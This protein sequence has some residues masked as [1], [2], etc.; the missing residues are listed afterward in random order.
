MMALALTASG[1]PTVSVN[2]PWDGEAFAPGAPIPL[3]AVVA[4]NGETITRVEFLADAGSL[5]DGQANWD[6]EW[7]FPDESHLSVMDGGT[8][9]DYSPPDT[10]PM[11][12]MDGSFVTSNTFVGSFGHF[13]EGGGPVSGAATM[14]FSPGAP[15]TIDVAITGDAP[16]GTRSLT[17]GTKMGGERRYALTWN[18]AAIGTHSVVAKVHYGSGQ[19]VSSEA[20]Q[21]HVSPPLAVA[22]GDPLPVALVGGDY[23]VSL[24]ASGGTPPYQWSLDSGSLPDG[25]NLGTTG[26]ITGSPNA[27]GSS[28]FRVTVADTHGLSA[29]KTYHLLAAS[30]RLRG[31]IGDQLIELDR[32][33]GD[34]TTVAA[35]QP[36]PPTYVLSMAADPLNG[37]LYGVV[38]PD[39]S[40][41]LIRIHPQTGASTIVGFIQTPGNAIQGVEGIAFQPLTGQ[42]YAS[43]R[44]AGGYASPVIISIDPSTAA[45]TVVVTISGTVQND[46]DS[47][48][49]VGS[50]MHALDVDVTSTQKTYL[51][52]INLS[53]GA[54]TLVGWTGFRQLQSLAHDPQRGVFFSSNFNSRE[55]VRIVPATAA[56]TTVGV[57][58]ASGEFGSEALYALAFGL[59]GPIV[60]VIDTSSPL[61][62]GTVGSL[63]QQTL[64]A[65]GGVA[66]CLWSLV[67]GSLPAGLE[68]GA[69][70]VLSGTP[71][72]AV[73]ANFRAR[74]TGVDGGQA[75][76][77]FSLTVTGS[78]T[79]Y[80]QWKA[81]R[82]TTTELEDPGFS[83]DSSDPERDGNPNLLEYALDL[84]P[85]S[86]DAGQGPAAT[87]KD[88]HLE[89]TYRR[90]KQATDMTYEIQASTS[91]KPDS[92]NPVNLTETGREDLGGC[93][94]ITLRDPEP[95]SG[96]PA[97]FVRLKVW[98]P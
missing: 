82:F 69:D 31:A 85:K 11:F 51:Y 43:C 86:P 33:T 5:G 53:T 44:T 14:V 89:F 81:L 40:P 83:G 8:L 50:T 15:D 46:L 20:I 72:S 59:P 63:Y 77:D 67:S 93:W 79:P 73:V 32:D 41:R 47:I 4:A 24:A 18:G 52:T 92:W 66:P 49:F 39:S 22:T 60:P 34:A 55:L 57:T 94:K 78:T 87:V 12:W 25:L 36:A 27:A 71:Q 10:A 65:S 28:T 95:V 74:V 97:R 76:R 45:A 64:A 29:T 68:L 6:G 80:Q 61:P 62:G 58:H 35:I 37:M 70:G 3:S 90:N 17:G 84:L 98:I 19:S 9:V 48:S 88:G 30:G 38:N 91:L 16:L 23:Q 54:A 13:P 7:T 75:E 42:L 21:V 2:R 1:A 26:Q 56:G 96:Q